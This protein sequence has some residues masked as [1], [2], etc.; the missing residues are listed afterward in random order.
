VKRLALILLL[1]ASPSWAGY[2]AQ[3][4]SGTLA[5]RTSGC[6]LT[7]SMA[8]LYGMNTSTQVT[9]IGDNGTWSANATALSAP[10]E[11]SGTWAT[12]TAQPLGGSLPTYVGGVTDPSIS[13]DGVNSS[14]G[15]GSTMDLISNS[16]DAQL[17][18]GAFLLLLA[19]AFGY[20]QVRKSIE[21]SDWSDE[22]H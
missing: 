9:A 7:I 4:T 2:Y 16:A 21:Q 8:I 17:I 14:S 22:K 10:R 6:Y 15:G 3:V 20:K 5:G 1:I 13:P 12:C 11:Q 18:A 19:I